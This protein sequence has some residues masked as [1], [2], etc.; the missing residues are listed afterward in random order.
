MNEDYSIH[1]IFRDMPTNNPYIDG[2]KL[3]YTRLKWDLHL[4]SWRSRKRIRALKGAYKGK[5]AVIICN[6]PSLRK[7]DL[8]KL[9]DVY[10]FGLNQFHVAFDEMTFRPSC[11]VLIDLLAVQKGLEFLKSTEIPLFLSHKSISLVPSRKNIT[12]MHEVRTRRFIRDLSMSFCSGFSV[13]YTAMQ[14]AYHMGFDQ[15]GIVGCDHNFYTEGKER[16]KPVEIGRKREEY[17]FSKK[18]N[19]DM[20]VAFPASR[21]DVDYNFGIARDFFEHSHREI[22]NC[23]EG[24]QLEVFTR[25]PLDVFLAL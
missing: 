10:T 14:L 1:P 3:I 13:T 19:Q 18:Y 16:L 20:Q 15:V 2:A 5:K 25:M 21:H 9:E 24:G 4:E 11:M 22:Y 7:V 8:S 23:T 17:Y 6:G 12:Y